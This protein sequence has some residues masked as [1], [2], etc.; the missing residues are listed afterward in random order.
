MDLHHVEGSN[1]S[2][3]VLLFALSTCGWCRQT[4]MF[5]E[6]NEVEYDYIYVDLTEGDAREEAVGELKKW[7][8]DAS[9]PTLVINNK[10]VI[11][12]F[13]EEDMEKALL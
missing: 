12:G 2:H 11:L 10:E 9:F 8:E 1:N 5:L 3:E 6:M 4:R 7:N 13:K